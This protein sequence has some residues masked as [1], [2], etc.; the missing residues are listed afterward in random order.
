MI[1]YSKDQPGKYVELTWVMWRP[2]SSSLWIRVSYES[3]RLQYTWINIST[4]E[5]ENMDEATESELQKLMK[6]I[7]K[8]RKI[9]ALTS[10]D[11]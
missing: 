8:V 11:W 3:F 6:L 1:Y 10:Q 9:K 5:P 4:H 7:F 2:N